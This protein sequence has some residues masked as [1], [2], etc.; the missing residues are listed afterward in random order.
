MSPTT[1]DR[2][3]VFKHWRTWY[4]LVLGVLAIQILVYSWLTRLFL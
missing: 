1:P 3:P 4:W 2:P